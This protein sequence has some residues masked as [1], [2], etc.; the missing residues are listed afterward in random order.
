MYLAGGRSPGP[1]RGEP[2]NA[3][4][5]PALPRH[6]HRGDEGDE[7]GHRPDDDA[8]HGPRRELLAFA[9]GRLRQGPARHGVPVGGVDVGGVSARRGD[10]AGLVDAQGQRLADGT[11]LDGQGAYGD[12]G[13]VGAL[14]GNGAVDLCVLVGILCFGGG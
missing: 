6:R 3:A 1:R 11:D 5:R 8:R 4:R 12:L 9:R 7:R 13:L 14:G 2:R 10:R